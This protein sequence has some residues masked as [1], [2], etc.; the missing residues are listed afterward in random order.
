MQI[1]RDLRIV[2]QLIRTRSSFCF[3]A[4]LVVGEEKLRAIEF[5]NVPIA[6]LFL[7]TEQ[8][9]DDEHRG[10]SFFLKESMPQVG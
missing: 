10:V 9:R 3:F 4:R 5:P 2:M 1:C 7:T 8:F 6:A